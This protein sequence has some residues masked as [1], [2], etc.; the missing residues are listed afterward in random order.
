MN[1]SRIRRAGTLLALGAAAVL[2]ANGSPAGADPVARQQTFDATLPYSC[3]FPGARHDVPVRVVAIAPTVV[4]LGDPIEL[5]DASLTLSLPEAAVAELAGLG[6]V[7]IGATTD[8]H[9]TAG[10]E[11]AVWTGSTAQTQVPAA[12]PLE[13][14]ASVGA[15]TVSGSEPGELAFAAGVLD[16]TITPVQADGATGAS[17]AVACVPTDSAQTR[18]GVVRVAEEGTAVPSRRPLP[19]IPGVTDLLPGGVAGAAAPAGVP[20]PDCVVIPPPQPPQRP[21]IPYCANLLGFANVAKLNGASFQPAGIV[22][23]AAEGFKFNCKPETGRPWLC[24]R[25]TTEP[26][27]NGEP[28][29]PPAPA[30]FVGFGFVPTKATMQLTQLGQINAVVEGTSTRPYEGGTVATGKLMARIFDVSVNGVPLDVGP[31]CQT[32][33]P[34]DVTLRG[35]YPDYQIVPGGLLEG[36]ITIPPF[37]GCGVTEDLDPILTG[38]V[39]GPGNYVRMTQGE[40]CTN[41]PPYGKCPPVVPIPK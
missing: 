19:G 13:L 16:L 34:I 32:A 35:K 40:I 17:V 5:S 27:Y 24:Q 25:A 36:I 4:A 22:N 31:N 10:A 15:P 26:R 23:I 8:L 21:F 20:P 3:V 11:E 14:V 2:A 28:K 38:M 29:L 18:F 1:R 9:A 30:S 7:V 41:Q 12:G 33:V 6:A 39:S 37:S